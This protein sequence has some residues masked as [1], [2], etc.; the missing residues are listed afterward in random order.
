MVDDGVDMV[1]H[2]G[3][4]IYELGVLGYPGSPVVRTMVGA[5]TYT[6]ADYRRRHALYKTDPDLQYAH[7]QCPWTV[8]FD[9]HEV[10][11]NWAAKYSELTGASPTFAAR[12]AAAFQAYWENMPLRRTA[13]PRGGSMSLHRR[14]QWG[15]LATLHVLDTR[16]YRDDQPCGGNIGPC[17]AAAA[18][19]RTILGE[20]QRDWLLGGFRESTARWDVLGNQVPFAQLD[21]MK[22]PGFATNVDGWDGYLADK[23]RVMNGGQEAGVRNPIVFTGDIHEAYAMDLQQSIDGRVRTVGAEFM[24]TSITSGGDG[25]ALNQTSD[26]ENPHLRYHDDRR[27]YLR[28]RFSPEDLRVDFRVLD[29][30]SVRGAAAST[31][32]SFTIA[33]GQRGLL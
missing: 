19:S 15:S 31:A 6:L 8:V 9:D 29:K 16:Q 14:Q 3:D 30:V 27:G 22:G 21:L 4:Y 25:S 7:A 32:R 26:L 10:D 23:T 2:L 24:T 17:T 28:A 18:P 33:D 5:E 12:R 1:L 20:A 13:F 11:N